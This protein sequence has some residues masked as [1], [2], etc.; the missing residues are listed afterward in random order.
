MTIQSVERNAVVIIIAV[1]GITLI[2]T[3][4]ICRGIDGQGMAIAIAA[5][6]GIAGYSVG[7]ITCK[8][9]G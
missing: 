5:I 1:I 2:E 7:K 6:V 9:E 4:A 3:A 8:K